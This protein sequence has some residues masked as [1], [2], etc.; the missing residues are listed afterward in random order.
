MTVAWIGL[1]VRVEVVGFGKETTLDESRIEVELVWKIDEAL[2][3]DGMVAGLALDQF[4]EAKHKDYVV[5][6]MVYALRHE[7]TEAIW[8]AQVEEVQHGNKAT[9]RSSM[10]RDG[11]MPYE[12][13]WHTKVYE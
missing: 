11:R 12:A 8:W 10:S 2:R 1:I 5:R 4:F 9:I 3:G 13:D 7:R 6:A